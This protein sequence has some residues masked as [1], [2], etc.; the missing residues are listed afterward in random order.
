MHSNVCGSCQFTAAPEEN[1]DFPYTALARMCSLIPEASQLAEWVPS[2]NAVD[3]SEWGK[4]NIRKAGQQER[5]YL[6]I[7]FLSVAMRWDAGTY[8]N[9][10][11]DDQPPE[12]N[13]GIYA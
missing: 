6:Q 13:V 1:T 7:S 3:R 2:S 10:P 8:S 5:Y 4:R 12:H 11:A 9:S